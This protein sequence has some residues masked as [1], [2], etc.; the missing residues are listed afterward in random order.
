[1]TESLALG[2]V[3]DILANFGVPGIVFIL[4][5][6]SNRQQ[7]KTLQQYRQDMQEMRQMY[8]DNVELVNRY[9]ALATDLKDVVI[10]NTQAWQQAHD[11]I[12]SNKFCP[13]VRLDKRA[14]GVQVSQ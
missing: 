13:M 6:L 12:E 3:V 11:G 14:S 8:L 4:W 2:V 1:M 7:E 5:Y 9:M 10:M